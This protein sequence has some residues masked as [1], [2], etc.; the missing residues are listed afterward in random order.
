MTTMFLLHSMH[1]GLHVAMRL[2]PSKEA[3][4]ADKVNWRPAKISHEFV[5]YE[6]IEFDSDGRSVAVDTWVVE[7]DCTVPGRD[8]LIE[9]VHI[10][11]LDRD[12]ALAQV[13][14]HKTLRT[15]C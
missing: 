13:D 9:C 8:P 10:D 12:A 11:C 1:V 5:G 3:A 6:L 7:D 2:Y 4:M 14:G 15:V